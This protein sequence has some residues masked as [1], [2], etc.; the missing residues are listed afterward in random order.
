[1]SLLTTG[2]F[3]DLYSWFRSGGQTEC[4]RI[5]NGKIGTSTVRLGPLF[6][7]PRKIWGIGLNY[8][9]H[10]SDLSEKSPA[11]E[12]ASFMKPDTA[13]IGPGD[14]V[15][16]PHQSSKTTGEAE[17]GVIFG[18]KAKEVSESNWI[19]CVAGFTTILDMTA[20]DIL[21]RNPRY[22]TMSKSFDTFLSFGPFLVT[23][24][25]IADVRELEVSTVLNGEII[26]SNVV[27]NM[28]F[29]PAQLVSFHS[30]IM[31]WLP[32][33]ILSTGTPRAVPLA[34]GDRLECRI[35]GFEPLINPVR[36]LKKGS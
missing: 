32:G 16:I 8:A 33:D 12:P 10:A 15:L 30:K 18:R 26:A 2:A 20:E 28:T 6:R 5:C 31:P 14:E 7:R 22:L 11:T 23:P 36:D 27:A 17:L 19:D 29:P 13:I 25:E 35:T 3:W 24:D 21:R 4:A 34:D 9:V 1:M